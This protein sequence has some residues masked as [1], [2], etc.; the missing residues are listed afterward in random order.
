MRRFLTTVSMT[1]GLICL[2]SVAQAQEAA[3]LMI[4]LPEVGVESYTLLIDDDRLSQLPMLEERNISEE[5]SLLP[6]FEQPDGWVV[7]FL[8]HLSESSNCPRSEDSVTLFC[9]YYTQK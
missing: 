5:D 4:E 1:A 8:P 6:V 2:Q 9:I 7:E 3:D